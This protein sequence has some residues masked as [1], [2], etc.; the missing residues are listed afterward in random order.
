MLP[1]SLNASST[2][3]AYYVQHSTSSPHTGDSH[4][5]SGAGTS[6]GSHSSGY[7]G[8]ASSASHMHFA[9]YPHQQPNDDRAHMQTPYHQQPSLWPTSSAPSPYHFSMN[10]GNKDVVENGGMPFQAFNASNNGGTSSSWPS[11]LDPHSYDAA[12]RSHH[13]QHHH[14]SSPP[15]SHYTNNGASYPFV[16]Q[17]GGNNAGQFSEDASTSFGVGYSAPPSQLEA[18]LR[19][20]MTFNIDDQLDDSG[21]GG[22]T[23]PRPRKK[24]KANA[25]P[26]RTNKDD[27]EQHQQ[28][29]REQE[30]LTTTTM[31][32]S[33]SHYNPSQSTTTQTT[34]ARDVFSPSTGSHHDWISS[35][36][37][38]D[39][40]TPF[41]GS[42][43]RN[44]AGLS[45]NAVAVSPSHSSVESGSQAAFHAF[46]A[47]GAGSGPGSVTSTSAYP[48]YSNH[49][50]HH[51]PTD[52]PSFGGPDVDDAQ[53]SH[54]RFQRILDDSEGFFQGGGSISP[55][56]QQQSSLWLNDEQQQQQY[57]NGLDSAEPGALDATTL[58]QAASAS[59][60]ASAFT[61]DD[62]GAENAVPAGAAG[63]A[64]DQ[65]EDEPLYVNPKQYGRII[66]RREARARMDEKR[67]KA[68]EAVKSGKIS[69][70]AAAALAG[71]EAG[72]VARGL[73]GHSERG[74]SS[75]GDGEGDARARGA[76]AGVAGDDNRSYQHESRHKHAMRRP[77][78]P[79]GRFLTAE[80]MRAREEAEK[81]LA[82]AT[83]AAAAASAVP[84]DPEQQ[85]YQQ[86]QQNQDQSQPERP[87]PPPEDQIK[88]ET[89]ND[90]PDLQPSLLQDDEAQADDF[91]IL[92]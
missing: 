37:G 77:R 83:A 10:G 76:S 32:P 33:H 58:A 29:V 50:S 68:E 88:V 28:Q 60:S 56:Q 26:I 74:V 41:T 85:Q 79:G 44:G 52:D 82:E 57:A 3:D 92:E 47:G 89:S 70:S 43:S 6:G 15:Y 90:I 22:T 84:S 11:P 91:L 16:P 17:H 48:H 2:P 35:G 73:L 81:A 71:R 65:G 4:D 7:R 36:G 87:P 51:H 23:R 18:P 55:Q 75:G 21:S 80:E 59:T 30:L 63:G 1:S 5:G 67:R 39:G 72:L 13:G 9:Q 69:A 86:Q 61:P 31:T 78:G 24:R 49:T 34:P 14:M 25:G 8:P 19:Y 53:S 20:P 64:A 42:S 12:L 46:H 27:Q 45:A 40:Y 62:G 66:K 38:D 54:Q